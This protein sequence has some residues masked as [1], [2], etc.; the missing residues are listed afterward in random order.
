MLAI[1]RKIAV[2]AHSGL[3]KGPRYAVYTFGHCW[4]TGEALENKAGEKVFEDSCLPVSCRCVCMD[5]GSGQIGAGGDAVSEVQSFVL[6]MK[7]NL[8]SW[9]PWSFHVFHKFETLCGS[10][11]VIIMKGK[12][13]FG[14]CLHWNLPGVGER[15]IWTN[16]STDNCSCDKCCEGKVECSRPE[17]LLYHWARFS[18]T[19][20]QVTPRC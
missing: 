11:L 17:T 6:W 2:F 15:K 3:N 7:R 5:Q 16:N 10:I 8:L 12:D 1:R 20:F 14:P 13:L 18:E 9:I 4:W 19:G